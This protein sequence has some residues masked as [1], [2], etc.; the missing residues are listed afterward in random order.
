MPPVIAG[1]VIAA[2]S[3]FGV[4]I[5]ATVA[6]VVGQVA[7]TA[8]LTAGAALMRQS[9]ADANAAGSSFSD[10]GRKETIRQAVPGRR[11][12]FGTTLVGGPMFFYHVANPWLYV[13]IILGDGP[14]EGVQ[15]VQIGGHTVTFDPTTHVALDAPFAAGSYLYASFRNGTADQAID[16]LLA[17]DFPALPSTFRQRGV[18]TMVLKMKWGAS[19]DNHNLLWGTSP[20]PLALVQGRLVYDPR[21]GTHLIGDETTWEY[22][23]NAALVVATWLIKRWRFPLRVQDIDWDSVKDAANICDERIATLGDDEARY[24]SH[25]VIFAQESTYQA[26][27]YLLAS[28]GGALV[29][30]NGLWSIRPAAAREPVA[31]IA[32]RDIIGAISLRHDAP[33]EEK[34]NTVR[35]VFTAR[36]REWEKAN[37]PVV[38]NAA[39]LAADGI[40]RSRTLDLDFTASASAAQRLAKQA[41]EERRL[42]QTIN[43]IVHPALIGLEEGDVVQ[44]SLASLSYLDGLYSVERM[45][46]N[47]RGIEITLRA[48]SDDIYAYDPA[49]DEQ[50]FTISPT[51]L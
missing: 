4:A 15:N 22:S 37:G 14:I 26:A 49:V 41:M 3:F 10:A 21:K 8:I 46:L 43:T 2:G 1:A 11:M 34:I 44:V 36:D 20:K 12:L 9:Q 24:E 51:D 29:Y 40:E 33:T 32:D 42:G 48:Y 5:G 25:G 6:G 16:P 27:Q 19:Q 30:R 23:A 38:I 50:P 18:A 47:D 13:G 39:Y 17:A 31:T 7:F 45:G 35:T 28:C